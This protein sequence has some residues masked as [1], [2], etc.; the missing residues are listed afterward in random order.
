MAMI[1]FRGNMVVSS[2]EWDKMSHVDRNDE[3]K[4]SE[5]GHVFYP[6]GETVPVIVKGQGCKALAKIISVTFNKKGTTTQLVLTSLTKDEA[7]AFYTAYK[8]SASTGSGSDE[9]GSDAVIPGLGKTTGRGI[10]PF[11]DDDDDYKG[12]NSLRRRK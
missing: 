3:Q 4:Y 6:I 11:A 7:N 5:S 9:Y 12:F 2:N 10:N 1:D 8:Y